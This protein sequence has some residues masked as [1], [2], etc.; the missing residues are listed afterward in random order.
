[1]SYVI[2]VDKCALEIESLISKKIPR[3][4]INEWIESLEYEIKE[5]YKEIKEDFK[6]G[7][8]KKDEAFSIREDLS[9]LK[10]TAKE[11]GLCFKKIKTE[12]D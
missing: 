2:G 9:I 7:N 12:V 10:S 4:T 3:K 1:M 11:F 8:I 6:K 5:A